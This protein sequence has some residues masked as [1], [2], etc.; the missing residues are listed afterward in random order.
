MA[1]PELMAGE[2]GFLSACGGDGG[3]CASA[4]P[5][6]DRILR[7]A[8]FGT[9][10]Q[11]WGPLPCPHGYQGE[12]AQH[13]PGRAV[14]PGYLRGMVEAVSRHRRRHRGRLRLVGAGC[15]KNRAAENSRLVADCDEGVKVGDRPVLGPAWD[16]AEEAGPVVG[17]YLWG[18]EVR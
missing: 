16:L 3:E 12:R 5:W 17:V 8:D 14:G 2:C 1:Q 6:V 18:P 4:F 10:D 9:T 15:Q 11:G 7:I 13:R